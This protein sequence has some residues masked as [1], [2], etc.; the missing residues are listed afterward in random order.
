VPLDQLELKWPN[1]VLLAGKKV[2]GVPCSMQIHKGQN[3]LSLGIGTNVGAMTFPTEI[4]T[5]ATTLHD[6]I[7]AQKQAPTL[8]QVLSVLLEC[9]EED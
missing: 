1:D 3:W 9:L 8:P 6:H 5:L 4:Q 7:E 2:S